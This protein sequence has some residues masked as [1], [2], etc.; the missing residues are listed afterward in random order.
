MA[1][2]G[3]PTKYKSE[4]CDSIIEFFRGG[5]VEY[6]TFERF[7]DSINVCVDTLQEWKKVHK[8]FSASYNRAKNIQ[9]AKLIEGGMVGKFN[10][11]FAKFVAINC[12]GMTEKQEL[13]IGGQDDNKLEVEIK[14]V[15]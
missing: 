3:T 6:P 4:Y 11:Q 12:H 14:V 7:A 10:S 9:K 8:N 15:D 1:K 13:N 5:D 2:M